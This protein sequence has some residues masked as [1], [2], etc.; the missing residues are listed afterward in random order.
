MRPCKR[1]AMGRPLLSL[2]SIALGFSTKENYGADVEL[3]STVSAA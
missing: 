1:L 2:A 3:S